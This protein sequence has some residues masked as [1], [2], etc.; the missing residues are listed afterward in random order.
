MATNSFQAVPTP[1][2]TTL[3]V[4]CWTFGP[5]PGIP[6]RER[7]HLL[8]GRLEPHEGHALQWQVLRPQPSSWAGTNARA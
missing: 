2:E 6:A 3:D 8:E 4:R 7:R 5:L 1:L